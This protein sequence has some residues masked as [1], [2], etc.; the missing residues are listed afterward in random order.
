MEEKER[1][2]LINTATFDLDDTKAN[3]A[4]R[5]LREVNQSY[6]WCCEWDGLAICDEDEEFEVCSCLDSKTTTMLH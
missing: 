1:I 3:E 5:R 2:Q 4:M 6:H